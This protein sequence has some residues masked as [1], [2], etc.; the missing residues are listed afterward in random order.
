[1][2]PSTAAVRLRALLATTLV[3]GACQN[4]LGAGSCEHTYRDPLLVIVATDARTRAALP[5]VIVRDVNFGG[6][7]VDLAGLVLPP[8]RNVTLVDGALV[9]GTDCGFGTSPGRYRMTV[10][11][12]G[13]QWLVVEGEADFARFRGGCPSY[14]AGS[15]FIAAQLTPE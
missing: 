4:P 11:A 14:N 2:S 9:C 7:P 8:A 1:M 10:A 15:Y 3:L 13:Y 6:R 12:P 5:R